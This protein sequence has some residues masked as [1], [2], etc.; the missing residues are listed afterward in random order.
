MIFSTI[1]QCGFLRAY[2]SFSL[3]DDSSSCSLQSK[4]DANSSVVSLKSLYLD[5]FPERDLVK[6]Y[7]DFDNSKLTKYFE[8]LPCGVPVSDQ[9]SAS[10]NETD[11]SR[12]YYWPWQT[13]VYRR[14]Y[15]GGVLIS[16]QWVLTAAHCVTNATRYT[17]LL[18]T[19]T[20]AYSGNYVVRSSKLV[21]LH[22][23]YRSDKN[24]IA[25]VQLS[26]PVE[27]TNRLRPACLPVK[28]V[29]FKSTDSCY[30]TGYS[31]TVEGSITFKQISAF[32]VPNKECVYL[33]NSANTIVDKRIICPMPLELKRDTCLGDSGGLLNCKSGDRYY[34]AGLASFVAPGCI[35][36]SVSSG[37]TRISEYVSWIFHVIHRSGNI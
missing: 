35:S 23:E 17:V 10:V 12:H 11:S 14:S 32:V 36:A 13:V 29:D 9:S 26:S 25:L 18:G 37:Y 27:F 31:N 28:G 20:Y 8:S 5:L 2:G 4:Y 15:C 1:H 22:D 6:S 21:I 30:L 3:D 24:D 16:A 7:D 19:N 33:W 34:I